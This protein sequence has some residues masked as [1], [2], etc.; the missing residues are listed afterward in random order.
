VGNAM[1]SLDL[2]IELA[3][4]EARILVLVIQV[5]IGFAYRSSFEPVFERLPPFVQYL[6]LGALALEIVAIAV[7]LLCVA[8][9]VIVARGESTHDVQRFCSRAIELALFPF[10]VS[11]GLDVY[12]VV[13]RQ[14][15]GLAGLAASAGTIL[16]ALWFWYGLGIWERRRRQKRAMARGTVVSRGRQGEATMH[17]DEAASG[18]HGTKLEVRIEQVLTEARMVLPGVQALLGFQLASMLMDGFD[19]LPAASK[20]VHLASLALIA[21]A[22]ILLM[23]PA[24]YHRIVEDGE[25]TES[26]FRLA[27][28][29]VLAAMVPLALGIA[30]DFYVVAA[31]TTD[32]ALLAGVM[33]SVALGLFYGLWFGFTLYRR[34]SREAATRRRFAPPT[35][36]EAPESPSPPAARH[37]RSA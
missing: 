13:D 8:Y 36:P 31:K 15:G 7:L 21:L 26:F 20:Y 12:V 11:L 5:L 34:R 6:K 28:R 19:K 23:T 1:A 14:A 32:S 29:M 4:N 16:V 18:G 37:Q 17:E 10:A 3:L 22:A 35:R 33:A 27:S 2:K 30:G 9:R 24:A 25:D